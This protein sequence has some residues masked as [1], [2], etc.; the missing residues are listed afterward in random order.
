MPDNKAA[1]LAMLSTQGM[2]S[3]PPGVRPAPLQ[4]PGTAERLTPSMIVRKQAGLSPDLPPLSPAMPM[5]PPTA[6]S[7][8]EGL[9]ARIMAQMEM[10]KGQGSPQ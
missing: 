10:I 4:S 3:A 9:L 1:L 2:P 8:K 6:P 7:P 5:A